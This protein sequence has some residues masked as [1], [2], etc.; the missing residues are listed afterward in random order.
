MAKETS[1]FKKGKYR[2]LEYSAC[3]D[4]SYMKWYSKNVETHPELEKK[5]LKLSDDIDHFT[6]GKYNNR[7]FDEVTDLEY[8]KWYFDQNPSKELKIRINTLKQTFN[9]KVDKLKELN[10]CTVTFHKN[11]DERG[12][13]TTKTG[14]TI[15]FPEI[16]VF[17]ETGYSY[18]RPLIK[19]KGKLIKNKKYKLEVDVEYDEAGRE[20][21]LVKKVLKIC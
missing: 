21:F 8:M 14:L 1:Y 18:A 19:G 15:K 6:F 2:G 17:R 3:S 5:I 13:I 4:L 9:K 11:L 16:K 12:M 20:F 10:V 7:K